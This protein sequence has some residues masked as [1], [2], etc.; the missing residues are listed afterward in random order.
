M[1]NII[2]CDGDTAEREQLLQD[3]RRCLD[4]KNMEGQAEGCADWPGLSE[5]LRRLEP[6][7]IIIAQNGVD[8]L[9][10]IESL[11][12]PSGKIIWF[13]DLDFGVQ[14][15]RLCIDYFCKKPVTHK[16][17]ERAFAQCI[18]R[19]VTIQVELLSRCHGSWQ[20]SLFSGETHTPFYSELELLRAVD[21]I[22][23]VKDVQSTPDD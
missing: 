14:A 6:D 22:L 9:N 23:P 4:E 21:N 11:R 16:K 10:T 18:E 1:L 7:I 12:L 2:V 8:G 19:T 3:I 17:L 20:G 13:S 15:Y 5:R